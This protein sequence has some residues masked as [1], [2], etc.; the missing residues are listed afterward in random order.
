MAHAVGCRLVTME[1]SIQSQVSAC[2]FCVGQS[3]SGTDF[4]PITSV[5]P[6][7]CHSTNAPYLRSLTRCSYQKD[8]QTKPDNLPNTCCFG[9]REIVDRKVLLFAF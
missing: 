5:F 7:Q 6:C 9:N 4:S 8:E 2:D 1:A 3:A